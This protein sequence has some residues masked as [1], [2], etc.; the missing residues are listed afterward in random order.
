MTATVV[1]VALLMRD[2]IARGKSGK[3]LEIGTALL[4]GGLA[5]YAITKGVTWSIVGVRLR[6]DAGLLLVVLI[7]FAI[8]QPFTLQ[9]AREQVT[10]ELW[11]EPA[12]IR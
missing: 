2:L 9:Y 3:V 1:A 12:F 6:V 11:N 5:A 7:S 10:R 4:F 8:R